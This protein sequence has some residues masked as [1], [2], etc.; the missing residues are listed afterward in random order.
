MNQSGNA[1]DSFFEGPMGRLYVPVDLTVV[2]GLGSES[3]TR[4]TVKGAIL[5]NKAYFDVTAPVY[6]DDH[7]IAPD[8]R[9]G[10][11]T[12]R[13]DEI[14][15]NDMRENPAFKGMSYSLATLVDTASR[16][17]KDRARQ[18]QTIYNGPVVNIS[19]G[20]ANIAWGESSVVDQSTTSTVSSGYEQL[21]TA[22]VRA[23]ETLQ[24]QEGIDDLE[25]TI[26][27]EAAE[28]A[29]IETT[30]G[31]P[32]KKVLSGLLITVRGVLSS[33]LGSALGST[34]SDLIKGLAI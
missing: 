28:S 11:R 3:E 6:E 1:G 34:V 25:R 8:P 24:T 13:V 30:K 19:G 21:A 15:L 32:D 2:H 5:N 17:P 22:L 9:G 27:T 23:I 29:L 14:K 12:L 33:A 7:L 26:A 18:T 10:T 16:P 4:T 31:E 20:R